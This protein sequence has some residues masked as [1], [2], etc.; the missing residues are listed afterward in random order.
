MAVSQKMKH[1]IAI[2]PAV[3]VLSVNQKEL[4]DGLTQTFVHPHS[5]QCY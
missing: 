2:D 3:P 5:Q 4:I 1:K